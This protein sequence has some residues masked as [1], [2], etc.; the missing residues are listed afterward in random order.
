[1]EPYPAEEPE[2]AAYSTY[3]VEAGAHV[4]HVLGASASAGNKLPLQDPYA[5]APSAKRKRTNTG[6]SN[7]FSRVF[8]TGRIAAN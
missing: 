4:V 6:A 1:M 5:K 7:I 3:D 8:G 2:M